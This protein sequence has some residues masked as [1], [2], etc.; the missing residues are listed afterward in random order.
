MQ[1]DLPLSQEGYSEPI[2]SVWGSLV[3][4]LPAFTYFACILGIS[5]LSSIMHAMTFLNLFHTFLLRK[6]MRCLKCIKI[7]LDFSLTLQ[8][9]CRHK[10]NGFIPLLL[11]RFL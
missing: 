9:S 7:S 2:N 5:S 6:Q 4:G 11:S 10:K 8:I 1:R 3:S